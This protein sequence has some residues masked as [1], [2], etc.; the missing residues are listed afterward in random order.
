M[1]QRPHLIWVSGLSRQSEPN[2]A[3]LRPGSDGGMPSA[4]EPPFSSCGSQPLSRVHSLSRQVNCADFQ[5]RSATSCWAISR[6]VSGARFLALL[7]RGF[8][9]C[10][11]LAGATLVEPAA[12]ATAA[13]WPVIEA[14]S[15]AN[16]L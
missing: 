16:A 1:Y 6:G 13:A 7:A 10:L 15:A 14:R 5:P 8:F 4:R 12:A 11:G 2:E 9:L 3:I